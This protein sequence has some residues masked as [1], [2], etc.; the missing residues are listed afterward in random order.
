M[1]HI[2]ATSILKASPNDWASAAWALHDREETV[3]QHY[4]HLAQHDAARWL[5]KAMDGPFSRM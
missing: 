1:R 5:S 3:K 4:A 2:V